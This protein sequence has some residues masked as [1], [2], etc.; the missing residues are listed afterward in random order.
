MERDALEKAA[1]ILKKAGGI[2]LT[3]L[4]SSDKAEVI[5]ALRPTYRLKELL[6]LFGISKSSYF[7]SIHAMSHDKYAEI[8]SK[9]YIAFESAQSC[10]GYR[11]IHAI[12]KRSCSA[13]IFLSHAKSVFFHLAP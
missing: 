8:R 10:Y 7:Y 11:R 3:Y 6:R 1:E 13:T 4:K 9:L 5:D 2:N 12:L